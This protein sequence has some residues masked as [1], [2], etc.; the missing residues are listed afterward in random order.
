M[1]N[2]GWVDKRNSD[3][4][5]KH[6]Q[7]KPDQLLGPALAQHLQ[8]QPTHP[9]KQIR[10]EGG[11]SP[12]SGGTVS[13]HIAQFVGLLWDLQRQGLGQLHSTPSTG[14]AKKEGAQWAVCAHTSALA[15]GANYSGTSRRQIMLSSRLLKKTIEINGMG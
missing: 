14:S 15:S 4:V 5:L 3:Y 1:E 13:C 12:A 7:G 2:R 8:Q 9:A 11:E 10:A 6:L